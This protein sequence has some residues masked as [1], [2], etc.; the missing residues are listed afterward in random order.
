MPFAAVAVQVAY[1]VAKCVAQAAE[2]DANGLRDDD[3][4]VTVVSAR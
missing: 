4:L 1:R 2:L 3:D